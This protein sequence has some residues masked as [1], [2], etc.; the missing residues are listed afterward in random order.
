[1][2]VRTLLLCFA[3]SCFNCSYLV[4]QELAFLNGKE[5]HELNP[6]INFQ[7]F[8]SKKSYVRP[9]ITDDSRVVGNHLA[10]LESWIRI[11]KETGQHWALAAY[12]PNSQLELTIGG[13]S[14]YE[15]HH[16]EN[17]KKYLF[18]YA[19]PL[20]QGKFLF[21]EYKP[22]Q[23]PGIGIVMGSFLPFGQRSFRPPG[24][25]TFGYLTV[26][27]CLGEGE[28]VLIHGNI[29]ANYL[30]VD[31]NNQ[32]LMT[33][34]LG[35]QI[36]VYKGMHFVG[37][38]FSGDPYIPGTGTSYQIGY[39]YFFSDLFQIDMTIGKG[40]AGDIILPFWYSAGVRI[41]TEKFLK[42]KPE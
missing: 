25:G 31:G 29:G 5:I 42:K 13:V 16:H 26:S 7:K 3:L 32:L 27:Q 10:Q 4:G 18:S 28:K 11:D 37:E 15:I 36:K 12:G 8:N 30:Y 19:L 35:T 41:V 23:L 34:G 40:I 22:N 14:G 20:I 24:Y 9:F 38:F 39:R 21:K 6:I 1:M 33:W 17:K 2:I